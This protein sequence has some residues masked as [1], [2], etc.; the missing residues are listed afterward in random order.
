MP[1]Q[2]ILAHHLARETGYTRE[3]IWRLAKRGKIPGAKWNGKQFR[4][5]V[6]DELRKWIAGKGSRKSR[7]RKTKPEQDW[8][9]GYATIQGLSVQADK[10]MKAVSDIWQEWSPA[11]IDQVRNF[12]RPIVEFDRKLCRKRN[13]LP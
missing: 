1:R 12:L 9:R 13:D 6:T 2:Q 7:S 4:F 8:G 3:W 5:A 11:E 10:W